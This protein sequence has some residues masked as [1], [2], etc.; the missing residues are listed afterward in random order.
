METKTPTFEHMTTDAVLFKNIAE[1]LPILPMQRI[2]ENVYG[3][4]VIT[5]IALA[6]RAKFGRWAAEQVYGEVGFVDGFTRLVARR[7]IV[8]ANALPAPSR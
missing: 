2:L 6:L 4:D 1:Q 8:L 5:Q 3:D 7:V